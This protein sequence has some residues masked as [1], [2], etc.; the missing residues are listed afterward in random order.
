MRATRHTGRIRLWLFALIAVGAAV[1]LTATAADTAAGQL[2]SRDEVGRQLDE[3]LAQP[4]YRQQENITI[5]P[6]WMRPL[7]II[8][9][10]LEKLFGRVGETSGALFAHSPLVFWAI[11]AALV[12]ALLAIIAHI[13]WTVR[14]SMRSG[15]QSVAGRLPHSVS[16]S[17]DELRKL[18]GRAAEA[19]DYSRAILL[20][21]LAAVTHLDRQGLI[22][23][24]RSDTNSQI[25]RRIREER[26]IGALMAP[27]TVTVDAIS[28]SSYR[29][30]RTR[31]GDV[32]NAVGQLLEYRRGAS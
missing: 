8:M 13:I 12:A 20:L 32:E 3:I 18:A 31:F 1:A 25:L 14:H 22:V 16:T 29:A 19:G 6:A 2:P 23:Y 11:V 5:D 9:R 21:Y 24:S 4:R 30:D 15:T 17:P 27:L 7:Q 28:Y 10:T 26:E